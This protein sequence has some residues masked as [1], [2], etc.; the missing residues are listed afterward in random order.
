MQLLIGDCTDINKISVLAVL[1]TEATNPQAKGVLLNTEDMQTMWRAPQE[2][3]E[4]EP[5]LHMTLL[6]LNLSRY[7]NSVAK[8]HQEVSRNMFPGYDIDA[9]TRELVESAERVVVE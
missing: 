6:A 7:A 9:M 2:S 8:K 3:A 1:L 5:D 4:T